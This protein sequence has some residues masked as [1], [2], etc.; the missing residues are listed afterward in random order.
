MSSMLTLDPIKA[1]N[2][3]ACSFFLC[4][5]EIEQKFNNQL[6]QHNLLVFY[7]NFLF[8]IYVLCALAACKTILSVFLLIFIYL[9]LRMKNWNFQFAFMIG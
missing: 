3:F 8:T 4:N 6:V 2:W 1:T 5:P 7:T 9:N